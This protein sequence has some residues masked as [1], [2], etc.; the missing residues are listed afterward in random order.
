MTTERCENCKFW[1]KT[2]EHEGECRRRP[3]VSSRLVWPD[4]ESTKSTDFPE[5]HFLEWCGEWK[6][7]EEKQKNENIHVP[8]LESPEATEEEK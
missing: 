6:A 7:K 2:T 8:Y 5:T 1:K 4:G 3:P